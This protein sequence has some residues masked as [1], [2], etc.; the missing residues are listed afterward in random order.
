[1][2]VRHTETNRPFLIAARHRAP[3]PEVSESNSPRCIACRCPLS[4][5]LRLPGRT[6]K[7]SDV[8]VVLRIRAKHAEH[9]IPPLGHRAM[10]RCREV[11]ES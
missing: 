9:K 6:R 1:M 3:E 4:I 10:R 5:Q 2:F 11:R 7:A 8:P